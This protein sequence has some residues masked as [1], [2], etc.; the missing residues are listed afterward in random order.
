MEWERLFEVGADG[1]SI[2][3]VGRLVENG[4][5]SFLMTTDESTLKAFLDDIADEELYSECHAGSWEGLLEKV[6]RYPWA[7]LYPLGPF[8]KAF[9]DRIWEAAMARGVDE[10]C[11]H[12]WQECCGKA[13]AHL[14][15]GL[16]QKY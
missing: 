3:V 9:K 1:G 12:N 13:D 8:H 2:T 14:V 11:L 6:D 15:D 4:Q 16:M 7:K 5:W 10:Y